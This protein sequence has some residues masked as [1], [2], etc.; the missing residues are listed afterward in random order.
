MSARTQLDKYELNSSSWATLLPFHFTGSNESLKSRANY[1]SLEARFT[2]VSS[3]AIKI[4]IANYS[5]LLIITAL[6]PLC[7][8]IFHFPEP[9][10]WVTIL[11]FTWV[12]PKFNRFSMDFSFAWDCMIS[13]C[14][15]HDHFCFLVTFNRLSSFTRSV[16]LSNVSLPLPS[17]MNVVVRYYLDWSLQLTAC[18][19]YYIILFTPA[20]FFIGTTLYIAEMVDD[21]RSAVTE[22]NDAETAL[23]KKQFVGLVVFQRKLFE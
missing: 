22:P 16:F 13:S 14:L 2:F 23:S 21:L 20:F 15:F 12:R 9:R 7:Y 8:E 11:Q 3:M 6:T 5:S 10:H 18:I 17:D 4:F 19:T 1:E